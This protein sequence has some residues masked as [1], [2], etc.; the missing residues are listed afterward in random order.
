MDCAIS[1]LQI[2][3]SRPIAGGALG[4]EAPPFNKILHNYA[5][6]LEKAKNWSK[7]PLFH[8]GL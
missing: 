8:R 6:L 7:C 2:G 3:N 1:F 5:I 4:I